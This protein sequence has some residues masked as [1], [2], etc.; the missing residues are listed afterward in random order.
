MKKPLR[1]LAMAAAL[2]LL[3]TDAAARDYIY[4][5]SDVRVKSYVCHAEPR[6]GTKLYPA[7]HF[8]VTAKIEL[9]PNAAGPAG[10]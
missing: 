10:K 7:D 1:W 4:V 9:P 3:G 2:S 8:L 6:P 5:S